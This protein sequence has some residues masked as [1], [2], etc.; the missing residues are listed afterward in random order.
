MRPPAHSRSRGV[1]ALAAAVLLAVALAGCVATPGLPSSPKRAGSLPPIVDG[2]GAVAGSLS[3]GE[4][5]TITG[6]NL[7][8]V[9]RV[10][11]GGR[12]IEVT[13]LSNGAITVTAP[14]SFDY[15]AGPVE[16][17]L[18]EA[19]A[20]DPVASLVPLSYS[21]EVRTAVDRQ[22]EYAFAHWKDYNTAQYGDFN[23]VG[24]DCMNFVSQTLIARGWSMT[25]GWHNTGGGDYSSP[26]IYAPAFDD[27]MAASPE[28][29]AVRLGMDDIDRIKVGDIVM[30]DWE[31]NGFANHTQIVS[32]VEVVDGKTE[33]YMVGHNL[34]TIYRDL[35]ATLAAKGPDAVAYFWS[36]P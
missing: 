34:D 21:Y 10:T 6:E 36:L 31:N 33:I 4:T 28:T 32:L 13:D 16:V 22:L 12:K 14:H 1:R 35:A 19:G 24:G 27:W 29:G 9:T 8:A 11:F 18:F 30:L 15:S 25:S 2:I 26:F 20:V 7:S 17:E 3:G 5:V 23:P